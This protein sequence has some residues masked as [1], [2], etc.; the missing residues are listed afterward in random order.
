M[1]KPTDTN[2]KSRRDIVCEE[3]TYPKASNL[4]DNSLT[5]IFYTGVT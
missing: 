1:D 5:G 4:K 3:N 2:E